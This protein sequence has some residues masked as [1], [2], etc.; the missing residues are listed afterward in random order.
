MKR[1]CAFFLALC[2]MLS[3]SAC[4]WGGSGPQPSP[5]PKLSLPGKSPEQ[6]SPGSPGSHSGTDTVPQP[7]AQANA[8]PPAEGPWSLVLVNG[9]HPLPQDFS[10]QTKSIPGYDD[11]MFDARAA[12]ALEQML[13]A[14]QQDGQPLYLVSSYRSIQRQQALFTRKTNFYKSQGLSAEKAEEEAAKVV[15]RPGTSEHNLG[16]AVDIVGADWYKTHD[17]LTEEFATTA[18]SR[19]LAENAARFGFVLRYPKGKEKLT[20]VQYEPWH[21]RYVGPTAAAELAKSGKCLEEY[22]KAQPAEKAAP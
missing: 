19:W 22:R 20:G 16:L 10:V 18:A 11:R 6:T 2:L 14:A 7:A 21:Y 9:E 3:C 8:E 17:D 4:R 5:A 12:A 1:F 15:A 13:D